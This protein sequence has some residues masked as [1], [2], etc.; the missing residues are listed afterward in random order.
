M[1]AEAAA[2]SLVAMLAVQEARIPTQFPQWK[3]HLY[4]L[5]L[6]EGDRGYPIKVETWHLHGRFFPVCRRSRVLCLKEDPAS[7]S[8]QI[9]QSWE[10]DLDETQATRL[11]TLVTRELTP[12]YADAHVIITQSPYS[13]HVAV[14]AECKVIGEGRRI[15]ATFA[16]DKFNHYEVPGVA[17]IPNYYLTRHRNIFVDH[18]FVD[19]TDPWAD[20]EV[21]EGSLLQVTIY[22][23]GWD[24]AGEDQESRVPAVTGEEVELF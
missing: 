12:A 14:V 22:P 20:I 18:L 24:P 17:G 13:G 2:D 6:R 5:H 11:T 1:A 10:R 7:W 21:N 19:D 23:E 9:H 8:S 16:P 4:D 3:R 15:R